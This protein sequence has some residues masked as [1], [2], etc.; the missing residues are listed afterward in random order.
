VLLAASLLLLAEASKGFK[1]MSLHRCEI[2][3][4]MCG[5]PG[6]SAHWVLRTTDLA[7][8]LRFYEEVLGMRVIRH[9][10]NSEPCPLT[11]N[12]EFKAA[13]SKTMVGYTTED[14]GYALEIT[15][16]YGVKSY[17]RGNGLQ[18]F[19]IGVDNP[20]ASI[21]RAKELGYNVSS[22]EAAVISGPD[23]YQFEI[24]MREDEVI[25]MG[26][27]EHF[28]HVD[29]RVSNLSASLA[30]YTGILGMTDLTQTHTWLWGSTGGL[31]RVLSY[32]PYLKP[33]AYSATLRHPTAN[34]VPL[35]LLQA[36][37]KEPLHL[38]QWEGRHAIAIPETQLL[39]IYTYFKKHAPHL[40]V[41]ELRKFEEN[42]GMLSIAIIKDPDS[43]EICLVSAETFDGA[44]REA[45]DWQ[46][47]DWDLRKKYEA[48]AIYP[49]PTFM[50][51]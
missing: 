50:N 18:V 11:C 42:L 45:A 22:D 1:P 15:Y 30:F 34:Q 43:Y 47:P 29:L 16:N 38:Q 31:R 2:G 35:V 26:R 27:T 12:G 36:S 41:H 4:E 48:T 17:P 51:T 33:P 21:A 8:A 25:A 3:D 23:G 49:M 19:G 13:W 44:V 14:E 37:A 10:E 7:K 39:R 9:E 24:V 32:P 40:I 28:Q 20:K 5:A 46:G 6:R